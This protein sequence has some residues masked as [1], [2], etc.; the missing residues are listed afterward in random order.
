MEAAHP[1][2]VALCERRGGHGRV[3]DELGERKGRR[4]PRAAVVPGDG[5]GVFEVR[6]EL[7][8]EALHEAGRE[9][10]RPIT[11]RPSHEK[12][13]TNLNATDD[14]GQVKR[15]E[16]AGGL[17]SKGARSSVISTGDAKHGAGW[18]ETT[19][20]LREKPAQ[21]AGLVPDAMVTD[22]AHAEAVC[23]DAEAVENDVTRTTG[24]KHQRK[25]S[26]RTHRWSCHRE[27]R[28]S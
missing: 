5:L 4:V 9:G 2:G 15:H 16:N 10:V 21:C 18:T 28:V 12:R 23:N 24:V 14:N 25:D 20:E 3:L 19:N 17:R 13:G 6:R 26:D 8:Q 27:D 11:S 7:G 22:P 1:E